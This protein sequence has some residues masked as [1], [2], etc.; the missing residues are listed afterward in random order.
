MFWNTVLSGLL[1]TYLTKKGQR[2]KDDL[3]DDAF[4]SLIGDVAKQ[5]FG[6]NDPQPNEEIKGVKFEGFE[7]LQAL[8]SLRSACILGNKERYISDKLRDDLKSLIIRRIKGLR[9]KVKLE[10]GE[11]EVVP[12]P[13]TKA[14]L[15]AQAREAELLGPDDVRQD[16]ENLV[17]EWARGE[18]SAAFKE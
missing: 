8:I 13:L 11:K 18:A 1:T 14:L 12:G 5:V 16:I 17:K 6:G 15:L 2:F 4:K 3:G 10:T 9:G 7:E